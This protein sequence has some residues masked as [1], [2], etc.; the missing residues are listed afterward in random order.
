LFGV[1]PFNAG[2]A[3][4]SLLSGW[5]EYDPT[6]NIFTIGASATPALDDIT[7]IGVLYTRTADNTTF[8]NFRVNEFTVTAVP[9][10]ATYALLAGAMVLG[11]VLLRRRAGR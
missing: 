3:D 7:A 10:P 11:L 4:E 8:A 1:E 2:V 9:E 5:S 6:V